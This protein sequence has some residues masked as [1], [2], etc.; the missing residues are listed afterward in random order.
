MITKSEVYKSLIK[1]QKESGQGLSGI[2]K[3]KSQE[4]NHYLDELIQEGLVK[5]CH[6]GGTIGHPESNIFYMPTK[7]YN[8]WED[9]GTDG[10]YSRHKGR[11]LHFVRLYLG[12]MDLKSDNPLSPGILSYLQY[13]EA[14]KE[15][16]D[17]LSRN[18]KALKE[19]LELDD[20]YNGIEENI[21]LTTDDINFIKAKYWYEKN[22][23]I[24]KCL[25]D[26][27]EGISS[28]DEIILLNKQLIPLYKTN[29]TKYRNELRQAEDEIENITTRRKKVNK[30][31]ESQ[32]QTA[33]IQSII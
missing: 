31:L 19:M 6:T 30:W 25:K 7:G 17:W 5:A 22:N 29:L 9:E 21:Q 27:I 11:Y 26:S 33:K 28:D 32:D 16:S 13:P 20:F 23:T 14:M 15:Y 8:V 3:I 1:V 10:E 2:V 24:A 18:D 12:A 4:Y